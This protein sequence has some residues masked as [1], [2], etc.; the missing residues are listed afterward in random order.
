MLKK[1]SVQKKAFFFFYS[2]QT[3]HV[4]SFKRHSQTPVFVSNILA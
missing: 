2:N 1:K 4:T 3:K